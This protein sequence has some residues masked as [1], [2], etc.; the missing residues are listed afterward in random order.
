M[1]KFLKVEFVGFSREKRDI[2][3]E[4]KVFSVY[5]I[6]GLDFFVFIRKV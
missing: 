2:I 4:V 5:L 3:I 1:W 6:I